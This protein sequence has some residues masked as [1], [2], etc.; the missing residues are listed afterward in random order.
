[1]MACTPPSCPALSNLSW[2]SSCRSRQAPRRHH[3][4]PASQPP[5]EVKPVMSAVEQAMKKSEE[6]AQAAKAEAERRLTIKM[7]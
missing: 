4:S 7:Q 1:M 3:R 6:R 2:R 5:L